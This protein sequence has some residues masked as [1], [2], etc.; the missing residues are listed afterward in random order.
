MNNIKVAKR[1]NKFG[2]YV[3]ARLGK[4]IKEVEA[5]SGRKVLNFGP[6]NPDFPPAKL[7]LDKYCEFVKDEDAYTY[8][9]FGANKDFSDA[10]I[11][12]YKKRFNVLIKKEELLPLLGGKDGVS[13]LPLA[14]LDKGDEV[15]VPDPGYPAFTDPALM[16]GGKPVYYDLTPK[17]NFKIS[18]DDLSKKVSKKTKFMW[19]NFPGNPT[20]QVASLEEIKKIVTFA[21]KHNI[22]IVYDDAYSEITFDG[23]IAP[24]ILQIKGAQEI[25]VELGSLSKTFSFAGFRIGWLVGNKTVVA[26]L[27][28]VKSQMDSGLSTPLQK[29]AA[30]SLNNFDKKWHQQMLIS[31][32]ER[33][34]II[35]GYLKSLGLEFTTPQGALYI[36]ASIPEREKNCEDFCMKLLKE[37]QILLTPGTAYGKNGKRFV[38]ASICINIDNIKKY[39]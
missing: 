27:A 21:K 6:G 23:F 24:S 26:A 12:W 7:Y 9:G 33:R 5:K 31:Y 36:W 28:K 32:K 37:K 39:F 1:L 2:E 35:A 13:H 30:F 3:F 29:L 22:I 11:K 38:R 34:D 8:P 18:I 17:N 10:L 16:I 4:N 14:L 25:A 19:V 20:G 15:L